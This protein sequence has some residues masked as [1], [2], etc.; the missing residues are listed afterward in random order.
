[1]AY[2]PPIDGGVA[3]YLACITKSKF[4]QIVEL[5][6]DHPYLYY[7]VTGQV[8]VDGENA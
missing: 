3:F 1:M 2:T 7:P 8:I 6:L 5:S 4:M